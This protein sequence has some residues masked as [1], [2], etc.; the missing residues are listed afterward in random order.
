[1]KPLKALL[2]AERAVRYHALLPALP[3]GITVVPCPGPDDA[4]REGADARALACWGIEPGAAGVIR[5]LPRLEWVHVLGAGVEGVLTPE[6]VEGPVVVT[7][8]RGANAP[9]VAEHALAMVLALARGL[10]HS[11]RAQFE[12]RWARDFRRPF[13]VA[14][15]TLGV[16]GYG[17]IG[18]EVGTRAAALGMRVI[19]ARRQPA[20]APGG[21]GEAGVA[22][23]PVDEVLRQ[24]DFLV[25]ALP[26]T[27]STRGLLNGEAIARMKPGSF[28]VN[29]ARGAI[30]DE[31]ALVR[32]IEAGHLAGA[33]LDV[34]ETEPLPPESPLWR[35]PEVI[36][37]A[38]QA[39][40]SPHTMGRAMALFA[41]NL[42]RFAR[43][44]PLLNVVDKRLGY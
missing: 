15:K 41:E 38:H 16:L 13:E 6:V 34:F 42:L 36:L 11:L 8:S 28:L 24:A 26:L 21:P 39:A 17:H 4:L 30:V 3:P 43:G 7:N 32:A 33:A 5:R 35:L 29:V 27:P 20:P 37:T 9:A 10:H 1:M 22:F 44:E 31:E 19:A 23:L 25:V 2:L 14:G 18:R 12:G 40:A